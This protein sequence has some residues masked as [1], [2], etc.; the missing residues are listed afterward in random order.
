MEERSR[1]TNRPAWSGPGRQ[2]CYVLSL[3]PVG[4]GLASLGF[5]GSLQGAAMFAVVWFLI[6]IVVAVPWLLYGL[7]TGDW[8]RHDEVGLSGWLHGYIDI[9]SGRVEAKE[10][11]VQVLVAPVAAVLGLAAMAAVLALAG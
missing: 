1:R 3:T 11:A 10:F 4:L 2:F 5:A 8:K 9:T 7:L 6:V